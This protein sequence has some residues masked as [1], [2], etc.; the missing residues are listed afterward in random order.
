MEPVQV[1]VWV[2]VDEDGNYVA[3]TDRDALEERYED[4]VGRTSGGATRVL[5]LSVKVPLPKPV[6]LSAEVGEEAAAGE[7]KAV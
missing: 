7:L 4:E 3:H 6:E 2:V 5:K 1:D